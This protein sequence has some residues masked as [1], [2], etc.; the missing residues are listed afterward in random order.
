MLRLVLGLAVVSVLLVGLL[1]MMT[2]PDT[3][4]STHR[5]AGA[6]IRPVAPRQAATRLTN[7]FKA[8]EAANRAALERTLEAAQ[9]K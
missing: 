3:A 4:V 9:D 6:E 5:Q 8:I 1:K 2:S 7:E